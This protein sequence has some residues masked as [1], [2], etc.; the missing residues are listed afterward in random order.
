MSSATTVK[1]VSGYRV[2]LGFYRFLDP[3]YTYGSLGVAIDE[4]SVQLILSSSPDARTL[5][6]DASTDEARKIVKRILDD[7]EVNLRGRITIDGFLKHHVGLGTRTRLSLMLL[8]ALKAL[9]ALEPDIFPY[10]RRLSIGKFSA[11]GIY[12]FMYGGLV[13]DSGVKDTFEEIPDLLFRFDFPRNW[14]IVLALPEGASGL[15]EIEERP[16]MT[17]P[18]RHPDQEILYGSLLSLI[19]SLKKKDFTLFTN[20]VEKIQ[21][22]TGKYF[23]KYQGDIYCCEVSKLLA[24]ELKSLGA[25]GVGQSSWGPLVYGF[26]KDK[27]SADEAVKKLRI[28][29]DEAGIKGRVWVTQVQNEGASILFLS[30]P[31]PKVRVRSPSYNLF[32]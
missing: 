28:Y 23:S 17:K 14:K 32:R 11:V 22:L 20:S 31:S 26:V 9:N 3:P 24:E 30:E 5:A 13:V 25:G 27:T 10:L 4:P 12:T 6:I 8:E 18:E 1:V 7:L 15:T 29:M 16:A 2:H 19:H 21:Q